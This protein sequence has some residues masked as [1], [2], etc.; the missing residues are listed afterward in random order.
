MR[1][2]PTILT[3]PNSLCRRSTSG[4]FISSRS[5]ITMLARCLGTAA[6]T[7]SALLAMK[8]ERQCS[9]REW[10]REVAASGLCCI[11]ITLGRCMTGP[12]VGREP[13][14]SRAGFRLAF[15]L[16]GFG[17]FRRLEWLGLDLAVL[18]QED[19]DLTL[20]LFQFLAAGFGEPDA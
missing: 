18:P 1:C 7:S 10:A 3:S 2:V 11:T 16:F 9:R 6:R 12:P 8:T 13:S 19:F 5:A 14:R 15:G 20:R 17:L 4:N